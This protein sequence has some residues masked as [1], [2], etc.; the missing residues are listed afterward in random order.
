M[1]AALKV[2]TPSPWIRVMP[3]I[4]LLALSLLIFRDTARAMVM[5]WMRSDTF[6]HALLVPPIVLWLVWQRRERLA[7]LPSE[8]MPWLLVPIASVC[9]LWLLGELA[10]VNAAT[11]LALVTLIV[12]SV[13][14]VFGMAVTRELMFPL[15][16]LY[17]CVPIGEFLVPTM[18]E[19]T[20]DMTVLAL[21][22]TGIPVY[23][24][25]LDF[26]IPSGSWSVVDA[27]SGVRYLIASFMVGTL[28][29]YLNFC[30][31]RR[32]LM[33]IA[34][35]IF[36]P[37]VANWIRAYLIVLIGHLS[38][39]KLA[40]G[41]DHLIY[42]WVF[43]GVVI[44]LMFLIGAR[45]SEPQLPH[46]ETLRSV[47]P[48]KQMVASKSFASWSIVLGVIVLL[49]G[50][51]TVL[52]HLDRFRSAAAPVLQLPDVLA[53]H[54]TAD[55]SSLVNWTPGFQRP[56]AIASRSYR[57][58][59][60]T[61]SVWVGY[62]RHED[63]DRKLVT[64]TNGLVAGR[65]SG[66]AQVS[67]ASKDANLTSG[68]VTFRTADLR[69]SNAPNF[70]NV[71]R[72]RVWQ[73]YWI[74]GRFTAS[75]VRAKLLLTFDRLTGRGDDGAVILLSTLVNNGERTV[76]GDEAESTADDAL[77]DFVQT[78]WMKLAAVLETARD[79]R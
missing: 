4:V 52:W 41:A 79:A 44:M 35:S 70:S 33:F 71:L 56:N 31:A 46:A 43:F 22:W 16:F 58:D 37:I 48:R 14:A 10:S 59:G 63:Y 75:D 18:M 36:V 65:D 40:V 76:T 50:I 28:F 9:V 7:V 72:L 57:S 54:W 6:A 66:W 74:G 19:S 17:F 67:S 34:V 64:S 68:S 51:Q 24:E 49:S 3:G 20:A 29:A 21:R 45:W 11:Q 77:A 32:R 23:R 73:V 12:L 47:A 1:S 13:P 78:N 25:G 61:V 26:V 27:C 62:Y 39:Y 2:A 55:R 42:G 53:A 5:V 8:P 38:S 15:S 30:S 69:A 60:R